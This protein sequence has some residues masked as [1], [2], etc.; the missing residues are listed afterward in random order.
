MKKSLRAS[1]LL[2]IFPILSCAAFLTETHFPAMPVCQCIPVFPD[3]D[4]WY[5]GDGAYSIELDDQRTL[6][7]FGDTFASHEEGRTDRIGMEVILGTTLAIST[8]TAICEFDIQYFLNTRGGKFVSSFGAEHEWLWPQDPFIVENVLYIPLISIAPTDSTSLFNFIISGYRFARINDFSAH[9]PHDW[10]VV[11]L[12]MT[13]AIA[14]GINA[15]ATTSVVYED[16][17]YFYPLYAHFSDEVSILGNILA[18][19]PS[20]KLDHPI[21]AIEYLHKDG[22]WQDAIDPS[23]IKIVLDASVSELSVRYHPDRKKWMAVYLTLENQGNQVL[24]QYADNLEG[25][26]SRATPLDAFISEVDPKSSLYDENTFCYAGKEHIEFAG[27]DTLVVSYVCNSAEDVDD[28]DNFIR[29]NLFLYRPVV[30]QV[31]F[32]R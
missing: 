8:C 20:K 3:K 18:R 14:P 27:N 17:V 1:L 11:Y 6:W 12:D 15:F 21:G 31:P 10:P 29:R 32:C 2:L 5:G 23:D 24:C 30:I 4:G 28:D 26:W 9:D 7:L 19:I 25:P 16:H 22:T 13:P